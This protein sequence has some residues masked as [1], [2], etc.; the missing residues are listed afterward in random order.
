VGPVAVGGGG[1]RRSRHSDERGQPDDERQ[2]ERARAGRSPSASHDA[3][4]LARRRRANATAA[5]PTT[6][7]AP[8]TELSGTTPWAPVIGNVGPLAVG[9]VVG[10]GVAVG[11]GVGA[12]AVRSVASRAAGTSV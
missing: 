11:A 6:S 9:A 8:P 12:A 10:V 1:M 2:R 5:A 4:P 7:N 3:S